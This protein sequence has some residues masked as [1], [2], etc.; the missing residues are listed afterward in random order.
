MKHL[1]LL[2]S[3]LLGLAALLAGAC[4]GGGDSQAKDG[5]TLF[6]RNGCVACHGHKLQGSSMAPALAGL[7]EHWTVEDMVAY[8]A[9]PKGYAAQDPRLS[10]QGK[11][12]RTVMPPYANVSVEDRTVLAEWLLAGGS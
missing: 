3:V 1:S 4:S 2:A 12:Y 5:P 8:L 6:S 11:S 10:E 7:A 9:D